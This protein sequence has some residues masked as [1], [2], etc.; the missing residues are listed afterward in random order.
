MNDVSIET[1]KVSGL[2]IDMVTETPGNYLGN[3][4]ELL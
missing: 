3:F 2:V 4:T 1:F